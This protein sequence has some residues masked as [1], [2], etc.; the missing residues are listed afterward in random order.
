MHS[1]LCARGSNRTLC[2]R[3]DLAVEKVSMKT[4]LRIENLN[5]DFSGLQ[6]LNDVNLDVFEGERH[7]IIGPNGSGKT[8]LF[9]IITGEYRPSHG[10]IYFSDKEITGW[11]I[12]KI[13]RLGISRSFQIINVF[14]KMSVFENI[15]N[16]IISKFN[17]RFNWVTLLNRDRKIEAETVSVMELLSLSD[18]RNVQTSDL[19]YGQQRHLELAL[20]I[21]RDPVFIMLDEPTAG[22][23]SEE[24]RSAI[25]L[26]KKLTDG[27]TLLM[28]EH[29]MD[30]VFKLADRIT[31]LGYGQILTTGTCEEVQCHEEVK[32]AYL[33]RK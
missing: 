2:V 26:I 12:H 29:D 21:A 33:G 16:V 27:K 23:N 30:V 9:N 14:P 32:K 13:A 22:L 3:E 15:R 31:V 10:R 7:A 28:V 6:V 25:E 11:S 20:T 18:V 24:T 19:S 4:I 17:R 5:K 1:Y 8:T